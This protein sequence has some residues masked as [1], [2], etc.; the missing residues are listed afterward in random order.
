MSSLLSTKSTSSMVCNQL[1]HARRNHGPARLKQAE[2]RSYNFTEAEKSKDRY[3]KFAKM[4]KKADVSLLQ[5]PT[6]NDNCCKLLKQKNPFQVSFARY[7]IFRKKIQEKT[8]TVFIK[9]WLIN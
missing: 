2:D 6:L 8:L 9:L 7:A 3:N 4:A 1:T 5:Y